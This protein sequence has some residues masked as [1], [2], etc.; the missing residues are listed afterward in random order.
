ML[1]YQSLFTSS[2]KSEE[3]FLI[4]IRNLSNVN[5]RSLFERSKRQV[6]ASFCCLLEFC[7]RWKTDARLKQMIIL[8]RIQVV[9]KLDVRKVVFYCLEL[10]LLFYRIYLVR[11]Y[12]MLVLFMNHTHEHLWVFNARGLSCRM[13]NLRF[14]LSHLERFSIRNHITFESRC[15]LYLRI[16]IS[17]CLSWINVNYFALCTRIRVLR[18]H[19][20]WLHRR[21]NAR[22]INLIQWHWQNL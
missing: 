20:S 18:R 8:F 14:F 19:C 11:R 12:E 2:I 7:L 22:S 16:Y 3:L 15:V 9:A 1:V 17:L 5:F 10:L 4:L 6:S 13:H 21:N